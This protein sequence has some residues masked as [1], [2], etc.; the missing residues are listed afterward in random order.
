MTY[1]VFQQKKANFYL[2]LNVEQRIKKSVLNYL[3]LL[4]GNQTL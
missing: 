1:P 2:F 3:F 4:N